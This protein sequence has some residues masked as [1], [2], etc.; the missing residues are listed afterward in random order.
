MLMMDRMIRANRPG[1]GFTLIELMVV[2]ML[3]SIVLAVAIPRFGGGPFQ[4]PVKKLSRW[5]I[6]TVKT[7]RSAAIQQ[8]KTQGLVIDLSNR[9]MWLVDEGMDE[10]A[11]QAA[12]SKKAMSLP[13]AVRYMDVQFP[14]QERISSGTAEVRFYPAGYSD[15]VLIHVETDDDEKLT[16]L[17]EPL[18]PKVKIIDEWIDF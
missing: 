1:Q 10:E 7:L 17:V 6:V 4:D 13:D 3:I 11:V 5:M 16:F 18:L 9:R 14:Q 15:Q 8:Q 12:A 2:M